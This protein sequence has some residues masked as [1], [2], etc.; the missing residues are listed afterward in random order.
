[1]NFF[2][3]K[4]LE[5]KKT[6]HLDVFLIFRWLVL[7][8][9]ILIAGYTTRDSTEMNL[10]YQIAITYFILNLVFRFTA[11]KLLKKQ[12]VLFSLFFLDIVFVSFIFYLIEGIT[13]EYFIFYFLTIMMA[14]ISAG[15]KS[16]VAITIVS[17]GLYVWLVSKESQI[18]FNNPGLLLKIVFL[19]LTAFIASIWNEMMKGKVEEV[20]EKGRKKRKE[21]KNFYQNIV[22]SINSGIMVLDSSDEIHLINPKAKE[23]VKKES[24]IIT[25][26]KRNLKDRKKEREKNDM[27]INT[28]G[29][30]WGLN[31]APLLDIKDRYNG[32]I[33]IFND[34]TERIKM[35]NEMERSKRIKRLGNMTLQIAHDLRNPLSAISGFSQI[36]KKNVRDRKNKKYA[37]KIDYSVNEINELI[38]DMLNFSRE[39][40]LNLE[41]FELKSFVEN[42]IS[43]TR[44]S[45]KDKNIDF[46][47]TGDN[48]QIEAD[49][50][51]LRRVFYNLIKNS[52]EAI[53]DKGKINIDIKENKNFIKTKIR[54]NGTGIE[55]AKIDRI[56][57]PFIT[58]KNNGTGLGL[59]IVY[60]IVKAHNGKIDVDSNKNVGTTFTLTLPKK[61][62]NNGKSTG[63]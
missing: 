44:N 22:N 58:T 5:I 20:K 26:I 17:V 29:R 32:Y 15:A 63:S 33:I 18:N 62:G 3:G 55:D 35:R 23:L 16:S 28:D 10:I 45:A 60:R 12:W 43:T 6:E 21:I 46:E 61:G 19:F 36:L 47:L 54:D 52:C 25:K 9:I 31:W 50:K 38:E 48:P 56:F 40:E 14:S 1:M 13:S 37:E 42:I 41:K 27:V 53:E 59:P 49:K 30:H 8:S 51:E 11:L 39:K 7:L 57:E 24:Q 34:I 4:V 2:S